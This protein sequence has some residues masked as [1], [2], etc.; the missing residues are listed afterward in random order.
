MYP[1]ITYQNFSTADASVDTIEATAFTDF[2]LNS[3][4][5]LLLGP[6]MINESYALVS[7]TLPIPD[8]QNN[9]STLGFMTVVAAATSIISVLESREGLGDTG[10]VLLI[11][12]SRKENLFKYEQRPATATYTAGAAMALANV[13]FVI[14]PPNDNSTYDRHSQYL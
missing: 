13:H 12:P 2:P 7:I 9:G 8:N 4:S 6:V 14:P 11:G 3:T 5:T 1:N 10:M